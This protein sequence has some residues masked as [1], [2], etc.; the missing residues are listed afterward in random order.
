MTQS[1]IA[2]LTGKSPIIECEEARARPTHSEVERL[3]ADNTAA[4][5][6]LGWAPSI[7]LEAGLKMTMEWIGE[8]L[9][10]Y[11]QGVYAL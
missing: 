2:S 8:H 6:L 4:R 11:R 10:G 1:T 7:P 3:V 9:D 5:R